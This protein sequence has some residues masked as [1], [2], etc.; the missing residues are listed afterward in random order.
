M[1]VQGQFT[2]LYAIHIINIS[3]KY[4]TI[5]VG[6]VMSSIVIFPNLSG[7]PIQAL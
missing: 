4:E 5:Y 6:K 3:S 7:E 1:N 2:F